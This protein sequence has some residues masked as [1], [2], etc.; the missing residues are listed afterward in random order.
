MPPPATTAA[1]AAVA[2]PDVAVIAVTTT[3]ATASPAVTALRPPRQGIR[4]AARTNGP[5]VFPAGAA[6]GAKSRNTR[7]PGEVQVSPTATVRVNPVLDTAY[8]AYLANNMPAARDGYNAVLERD[9]ANRDALLGLAG[10]AA[11]ERRYDEAEALYLRILNT[12]PLDAYAQTGLIAIRGQAD[13]LTA[14]SRLKTLI[15]SRPD[16]AFLHYAL[17]NLYAKQKR[18]NDAEQEH[19]RA[20][21]LDGDNADY[22]YNLAVSLDQ[23]RQSSQ[24]LAHYQ[25][26]L[27]L[28]AARP[29]SF[30]A[31]RLRTRIS[32]LQQ[33]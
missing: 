2:K 25:R 22:C 18:W 6:A 10:V 20:F 9:P 19:F 31:D 27:A 14:E 8:S 33:P 30:D 26:A 17:G 4:V 29:A 11:R 23:M 24:A 21:A 3:P 15:A 12:D 16:A 5:A 28:A 13:P 7:A 32:E 1:A